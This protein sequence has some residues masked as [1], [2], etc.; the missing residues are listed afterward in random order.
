MLVLVLLTFVRCNTRRTTGTGGT[1]SETVI[2]KVAARDGS[3]ACSSMVTLYPEDYDPIADAPLL[4]SMTD[5]TDSNGTYSIR[6]PDTAMNYSIIAIDPVS[7]TRAFV[8]GIAAT[9]ETTSA[10]DAVLSTPGA[11]NVAVPDSVSDGYVYIPG[12]G[13]V[14]H[15]N[16]N[17]TVLLEQVPAGMIPSVVYVPDAVSGNATILITDIDVPSGDTLVL[18]YPQWRNYMKIYLNTTATGAEIAEDVI[19]FPVLIRLTNDVFDFAQTQT[20]GSAIRFSDAKNSR[21]PYEIERWD[22]TT[23][24]AEIW[25][26]TDTVFGNDST[27][28]LTMYWGNTEAASE[29]N[30]ASV[31]DT[32]DGFQ[33]VWHLEDEKNTVIH[34]ATGNHYDGTAY[35]T[36]ISDGAIGDAHHFDGSSS[37]IIIDST[38]DS[39]LNMP[40]NGTYAMS[41]WVSADTIDTNWQAIAGKGH[42]QYYMQFKA[43]GNNRATW[44]FVEYQDEQGWEYT[45]DSVPPAPGAQEWVY[46][47]G[48]RNGNEQ[49]LYINGE[50]VVDAAS[51]DKGDYPRVVT[52]DFTIGCY[53]RPVTIPINQQMA[54]FDGK[55][56]EVRVMSVVPSTTWIKLCYMNQRKVNKLII[57]K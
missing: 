19:D 11:V 4:P 15:V 43:L 23:G 34:D 41:L 30:S 50:K 3:P 20:D 14:V 54:Y 42:E 40:Q 6:L 44:E 8:T 13:I 27:Q 52:D 1:G 9:G 12:T 35:N 49:Q 25:V 48:I 17:G 53:G 16:N 7:K 29:S 2:G 47:V 46:M 39:R 51:L 22:P 38:A 21:L 55:I 24:Q 37:H 10:P 31:F 32:A 28:Y 36:L 56:D 26:R 57:F 18:P 45:E 5:T 33:G